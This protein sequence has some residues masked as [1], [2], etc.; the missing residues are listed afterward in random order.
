[1]YIVRFKLFEKLCLAQGPSVIQSQ[2]FV[3][4]LYKCIHMSEEQK[5]M[6]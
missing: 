2:H 6:S 5:V 1:M 3:R 4:L